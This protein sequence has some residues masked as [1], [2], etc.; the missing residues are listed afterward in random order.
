MDYNTSM[1]AV[2]K[3]DQNLSSFPVMHRY[4]CSKCLVALHIPDCFSVYHHINVDSKH[5]TS[6]S[7]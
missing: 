2:D 1:N 3:K 5:S 4:E 6:T 7:I